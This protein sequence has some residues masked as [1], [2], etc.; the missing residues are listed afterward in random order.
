MSITSDSRVIN[1]FTGDLGMQSIQSA[2]ENANSPGSIQD[3]SL[4]LGANTITPPA[5]STGATIVFP[6][7]NT[8]LVTLKGVT[9]DTGIVLHPTDPTRIGLNSTTAFVLTAAT[10]VAIRIIWS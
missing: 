9:G 2:L 5:N 8:V 6:A 4:A 3:I 7:A 10:S 1:I